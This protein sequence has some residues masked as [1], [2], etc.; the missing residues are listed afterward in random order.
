[1]GQRI[2]AG[3]KMPSFRYDTPYST[4]NSFG[5]LLQRRTPLV[6][7]FLSNFGH[8]VTRTFIARY[9][10]GYDRMMDGG[11]AV[12]VRSN[13]EKLAQSVHKGSLPFP[14]LCD[15]EGALYRYLD[16]PQTKNAHTGS[17]EAWQ[18]LR[19]A[20]KKGYA[21]PKDA[22]QQLPLTLILALDGTVLFCHYGTNLT[23]IPADCTAM[24][25][26]LETLR[27]PAGAAARGPRETLMDDLAQEQAGDTL[28]QTQILGPLDDPYPDEEEGTPHY[29]R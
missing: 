24:Q 7:V 1:M 11:L 4:Q 18:I 22:P 26:L 3:E 20:R 15:A 5:A 2:M 29:T 14:L 28:E 23:D 16:I 10:A 25:K 12:V 13:P 17:L 9:A 21:A 6:L 27:T 19:A 8:P